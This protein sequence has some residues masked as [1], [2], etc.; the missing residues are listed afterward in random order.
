MGEELLELAA[1]VEKAT[2][3]DRGLDYLI[4]CACVPLGESAYWGPDD[5][6]NHF[7]GSLDAALSLVPSGVNIGLHIDHNGCDCAWSSRRVGWQPQVVPANAPALALTA[8]A[9]RALHAQSQGEPV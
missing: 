8:A 1:R 6:E 9:L 5:R 3:P 7:T 2:G 4:F